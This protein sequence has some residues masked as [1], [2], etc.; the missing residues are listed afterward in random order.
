M[1]VPFTALIGAFTSFSSL[2]NQIL[3]PHGFTD[4]QA[5][6][7]GAILILAGLTTAAILSPIIDHSAAHLFAIKLGIPLLAMLYLLFL[8]APSSGSIIFVDICAGLIGALSFSLLPIG[9]E[10]V[11]DVTHPIAVELSST[12]FWAGGQLLGGILMICVG[13][14]KASST[15]KVPNSLDKGLVIHA[16]FAAFAM[17]FAIALGFFGRQEAVLVRRGIR[18]R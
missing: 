10:F 5:G 3:V 1:F 14:L 12:T 7:T 18:T 13:S 15:D 9:L 4:T 6:I 2:L 17:P 11:A 8:W 16:G